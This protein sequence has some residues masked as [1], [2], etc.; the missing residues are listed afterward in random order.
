M[1]RASRRSGTTRWLSYASESLKL[2]SEK[3]SVTLS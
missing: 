1:A 2:A 3:S